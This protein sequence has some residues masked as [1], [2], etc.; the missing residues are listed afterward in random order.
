M[1]IFPAIDIKNGLPVRL[2]KGD[3][4][5]AEQVAAS[6][7][8]TA[9]EFKKECNNLHLVDL[10]GA[11]LG[12]AENFD[13]ICETVEAFNGFVEVGGGIRN[14]HTVKYYLDAGVSRVILGTSAL[15]NPLL[16]KELASNFGDKVSVGIDARDGFVATDGWLDSSKVGYI[17]FA[18]ECEQMGI[19]T[20]I[21][22]DI[23]KD[24]T[25]LGPNL[26]QTKA[27][28]DAIKCQ[29]I[30]SGGI[31]S[32]E[33]IRT[34]RKLGVDGA[35]CGKSLYHGKISLKEAVSVAAGEE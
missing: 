4:N 8:E 2:Y 12:T 11:K 30:V 35:I 21:F 13:L 15:K 23:S 28:R 27:L 5:T 26:D 9:K 25:L 1:Q 10:D 33:D 14:I 34:L 32:I 3:F 16:L 20:I 18:R 22:T 17:D 29:L 7:L 19:S 6:V 24:G 31:H